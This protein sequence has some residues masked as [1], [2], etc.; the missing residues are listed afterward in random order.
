MNYMELF[1]FINIYSEIFDFGEGKEPTI[2]AAS[3][4]WMSEPLPELHYKSADDLC[5]KKDSVCVIYISNKLPSDSV[6]SSLKDV[7]QSFSSQLDNR[8]VNF[9]FMWVDSTTQSEFTKVFDY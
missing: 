8:G 6:I 9:S 7:Q 1:N 3:K 4:P 5:F 2:S